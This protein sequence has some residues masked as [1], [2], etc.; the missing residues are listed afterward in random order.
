MLSCIGKPP[1]GVV[2]SRLSVFFP[3]RG[4]AGKVS[5]DTGPPARAAHNNRRSIH[6]GGYPAMTRR[7]SFG[8]ILCLTSVAFADG[9]GDNN[10]NAVKRIPPVGVPISEADRAGLQTGVD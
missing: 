8:L 3:Q 5:L 1:A 7:C 4:G 10:E 6:P 9:P 2:E